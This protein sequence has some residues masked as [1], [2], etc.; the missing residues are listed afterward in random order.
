MHLRPLLVKELANQKVGVGR[1]FGLLLTFRLLIKLKYLV[2]NFK[3]V[4]FENPL[5]QGLRKFDLVF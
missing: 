5:F 4:V 3:K 2:A 1:D